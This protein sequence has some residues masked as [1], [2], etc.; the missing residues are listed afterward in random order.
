MPVR[1]LGAA[2]RLEA[3]VTERGASAA[4]A[5]H[6]GGGQHFGGHQV[7]DVDVEILGEGADLMLPVDGRARHEAMKEDDH[8]L[9]RS[10]G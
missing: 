10:A 1:D 8:G 4:K 3:C 9:V 5:A 2:A 6:L 7:R